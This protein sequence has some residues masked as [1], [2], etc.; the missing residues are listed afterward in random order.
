M[1]AGDESV[2]FLK[3]GRVYKLQNPSKRQ[4]KVQLGVGIFPDCC[5]DLQM[6]TF[7]YRETLDI[8]VLNKCFAVQK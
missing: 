5:I 1:R 8:F 4:T 6:R 7:N 2:H 3:G